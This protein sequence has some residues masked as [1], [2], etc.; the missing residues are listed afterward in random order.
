MGVDV[1]GEWVGEYSY[2]PPFVRAAV[3]FRLTLTKSW[4]G[5]FSGSVS[6]GEGGMPEV[7]TVKGWLRGKH[8]SFKKQM[9]VFRVF[10]DGRNLPLHEYVAAKGKWQIDPETPHPAI[11][12]MGVV[13]DDGLGLEGQWV[14]EACSVPLIGQLSVFRFPGFSG[15][16]KAQRVKVVAVQ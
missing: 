4:L 3:P 15:T 14:V 8:L 12:Y 16:W 5:W 10:E 6:D 11:T 2:G 9:P 13:T 1:T 7:G